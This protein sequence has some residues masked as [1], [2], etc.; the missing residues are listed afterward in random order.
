[1]SPRVDL[2]FVL[3][4]ES[5]LASID[6]AA[7]MVNDSAVGSLDGYCG[8]IAHIVAHSVSLAQI[9]A[10]VSALLSASSTSCAAS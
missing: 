3:L 9:A 8:S 4:C 7:R 1:M 6:S 2:L 10:T 5:M